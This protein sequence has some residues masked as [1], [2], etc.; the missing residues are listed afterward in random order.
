MVIEGKSSIDSRMF[1]LWQE[2]IV[3]LQSKTTFTPASMDMN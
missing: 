3:F 2:L 1:E